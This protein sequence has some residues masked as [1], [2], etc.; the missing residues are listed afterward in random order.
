MAL[1]RL[2]PVLDDRQLLYLNNL[3]DRQKL[4]IDGRAVRGD[5]DV[6][7]MDVFRTTGRDSS[8][9]GNERGYSN[10]A[11]LLEL[12]SMPRHVKQST[13]SLF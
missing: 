7:L 6:V 8:V 2:L 13:A 12:I 10:P 5:I 9:E 1:L 3:A 11:P 4:P